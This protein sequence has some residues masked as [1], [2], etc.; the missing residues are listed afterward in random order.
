MRVW[1][2]NDFEAYC[3][4]TLLQAVRAC[5]KDRGASYEEVICTGDPV[6]IPR[7]EWADWHLCEVEDDFRDTTIAEIMAKATEP[8]MIYTQ[9]E[10]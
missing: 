1:R 3:G 2:L 8:Q 5:M 9:E 4:R 7:E 6:E 10:W